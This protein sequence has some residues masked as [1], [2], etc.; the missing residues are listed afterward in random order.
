MVSDLQIGMIQELHMASL[1]TSDDWWYDSDATAHVCNN[2][3]LFKT[4][5]ESSP[6]HE[7]LL[8]DHHSAD[9][10]G[11]GTVE[12]QFTSGKKVILTNVF[13]VSHIRKNLI[14]G[15][16]LCKKYLNV[17]IESDKIVLYKARVFVRKGYTCDGMFKL[18]INKVESSAYY[19]L[20]AIECSSFDLWHNRLAHVNYKTMKFMSKSVMISY[21]N[22][23]DD[24]CEICV[25]AKMKRKPFPKIERSTE[26]L[27]LES[28][29]DIAIIILCLI[30]IFCYGYFQ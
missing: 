6:D 10:K 1:T 21:G 5:V 13:H 11:T 20:F 17:V 12:V 14:S 24:K 16:M 26:I 4:Y 19:S 9:V 25:Q 27:E 18:S 3:A 7:V 23:N 15:Y 2:K 8:G 30:K 29:S 28:H 22:V